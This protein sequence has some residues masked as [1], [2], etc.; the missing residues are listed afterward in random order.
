VTALRFTWLFMLSMLLAADGGTVLFHGQA[1]DFDVTVFSKS[2]AVRAGAN[3]FS[4][5]VQGSDHATVMNATVLLQ[6]GRS[7]NSGEIMRITGIATHAKA[8]N[9]MLYASTV[10]IPATGKWSLDVNVTSDGKNGIAAGQIY[11]LPPAP[12][13]QNYWPLVLM[14]PLLGLAFVINRRLRARFRARRP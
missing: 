11:V 13:I 7:Q 3:D 4:V 9:K 10:N 12:P 2:E 6:L 8:T 14:V 5:L 1:G